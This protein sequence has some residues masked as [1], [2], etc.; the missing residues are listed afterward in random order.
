MS[1]KFRLDKIE[2]TKDGGIVCPSCGKE[3][4][5][6][7]ERLK[8]FTDNPDCNTKVG[9]MMVEQKIMHA[10]D[11]CLGVN[12]AKY[13]PDNVVDTKDLPQNKQKEEEKDE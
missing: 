8:H 4:H 5:G 2:K 12:G 11:Q 9:M 10:V 3:L 1:K 7:K 13:Y 6:Y